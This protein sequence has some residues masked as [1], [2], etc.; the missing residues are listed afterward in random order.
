MHT[1]TRVRVYVRMRARV[2]VYFYAGLLICFICQ[3][4][5]RKYLR[6]R[7]HIVYG[8]DKIFHKLH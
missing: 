7:R 1:Y 8:K 5:F 6:Y 2:H 4:L 3:R